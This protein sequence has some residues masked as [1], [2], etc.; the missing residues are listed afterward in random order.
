MDGHAVVVGGGIGGLAGA[1]ALHR[2]GWRVTVLERAPELR[3]L[4]A[5][6]T[7]MSNA[8]RGLDA[9]G[10]GPAIRAHGRVD[11]PGG[12]RTRTGRWLSRVEAAGMT[13]QLGTTMLGIHRADLHGIL[14][15]ALPPGTLRTDA[16][17]LDVTT[18]PDGARVRHRRHSEPTT[19]AADLVVGADGLRSTVRSR[20]WP[21]AAAPVYA[22]ATAWRAA[23]GWTDPLPTA[24]SWGPAAEFGM[25]PLGGG[26]V[27]WYGAVT[28][29]AGGRAPDELAAAREHFGDWHDPVPALLAATAPEQVL[30]HDLYHLAT[31]L[32][33]YVHGRV[34]LLG[35]AA[36]AMTPYL[37]Q[38][39]AQAIEDAVTLGAACAG[40]P[41]HLDTA[42]DRY[43]RE[44][45]PRT[46]ALAR[47]SARAGRYG[48]QLRHPV[49]VAFRDTLIR[50]T[51]SAMALRQA[52]RYADW[53]PPL[54]EPATDR[55]A[56]P[57]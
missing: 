43:D 23:I 42:L 34:V 4:G 22:G 33:S 7:L 31:P 40:G 3:E 56:R 18:G 37:G 20:L 49:A 57:W 14:R 28:A 45:R 25:V 38:G 36:H 5:G 55:S 6:L 8:L 10:V 2:S 26:R 30:R 53:H 11:G 13:G 32:P 21:D 19:L 50:L 35:D 52:A 12:L 54:P 16:E 15:D 9:L 44:R 27:Y 1:L 24:V 41:A 51:P 17:V 48:Q 39:A 29:P 46:Q 47:A